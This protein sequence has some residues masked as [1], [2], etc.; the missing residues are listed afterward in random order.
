MAYD[1]GPVMGMAWPITVLEREGD[2]TYRIECSI[3]VPGKALPCRWRLQL[4]EF[5]GY[6]LEYSLHRDG[7][8]DDEHT[9]GVAISPERVRSML[10]N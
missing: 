8:R 1:G 5:D 3:G 7:A 6:T 10:A 2:G 4:G 9:G